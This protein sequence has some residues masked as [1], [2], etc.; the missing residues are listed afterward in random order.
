MNKKGLTPIVIV[1]I[2]LI[3]ALALGIVNVADI[4]PNYTTVYKANYGHICCVQNDDYDIVYTKLLSQQKLFKCDD[5]TN[6][7]EFIFDCLGGICNGKYELC[8]IN[9]NNCEYYKQ[10]T[11]SGGSY[12]NYLAKIP[13]GKSYKFTPSFLTDKNSRIT[14]KVKSFYIEGEENGKIYTQESCVL[15]S[16]LRG[17]VTS[18]GLN[19]LSK[20]GANKCQNY[21]TDFIQVE[22]KTYS[23]LGKEVIC[24][25]RQLYNID[26]LTFK[27]GSR[28]KIQG[29]YI[30]AVACCPTENNCGDGFEFIADKTR[31][32]AYSTECSNGGDWYGVS[33]ITARKFNCV[34]GVCVSEDKQVECTSTAVCIQR[35]GEGY[36]C[37]FTPNNWGNCIK[38]TTP[39][40][41]GDGYCQI[42]ES[43][44]SCPADCE[45][46]CLEGEK[47]VTTTKKVGCDVDLIFVK[48]GCD[49]IVEK[50]C[51]KSGINWLKIIIVLMALALVYAFRGQIWALIKFGGKKIGLG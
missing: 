14:K 51:Q 30:K 4:I 40:Y 36:V 39:E 7:C 15:S 11:Y 48:Y 35:Y 12:N 27:D 47:L 49:E 45:L 43:K 42:G 6:E 25:A 31:E 29:D 9:G 2:L 28:K 17:K 37:D 34:N 13:V 41:C 3:G 19:E 44:D 32:C 20:T 46:E 50:E 1:V 8:D 33:G 10:Y 18:D 38:S 21:I 23:Y 16:E 5:Y 26:T 22:T 24:Q